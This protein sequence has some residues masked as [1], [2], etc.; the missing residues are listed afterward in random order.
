MSEFGD[1]GEAQKAR[2]AREQDALSNKIEALDKQIEKFEDEKT[3]MKASYEREKDPE[4]HPEFER[5]VEKGL[6][7]ITNK[8]DELKKR[9][10]ELVTMLKKLENEERQLKSVLEHERYPELVELKKKRDM[11][12]EEVARLEDEMKQLMER[13]IL[14][15]RMK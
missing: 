1:W 3:Q 6:T 15:T 2:I 10:G 11:A 14:E 8:Q 4:L 13:M 5:L 7:R 12:A 9:R